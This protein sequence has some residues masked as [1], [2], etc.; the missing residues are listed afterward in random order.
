MIEFG[1]LTFGEFPLRDSS[2]KN[3]LLSLLDLMFKIKF[4]ISPCFMISITLTLFAQPFQRSEKG[5][6]KKKETERHRD[7]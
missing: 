7:A 3:D 1:G 2:Q 5:R 6:E 4:K